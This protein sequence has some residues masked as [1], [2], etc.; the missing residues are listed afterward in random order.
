MTEG[1]RSEGRDENGEEV[2]HSLYLQLLLVLEDG[3]RR[4]RK[5]AVAGLV[6]EDGGLVNRAEAE[7]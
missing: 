7:A 1:K 5:E 3:E 6:V 4:N 2:R